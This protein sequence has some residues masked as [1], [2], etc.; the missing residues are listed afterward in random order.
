VDRHAAEGD[1]RRDQEDTADA[2]RANEEADDDGD[3]RE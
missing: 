3:G 2:Y 1:E